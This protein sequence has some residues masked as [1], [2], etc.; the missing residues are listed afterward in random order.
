MMFVSG[1]MMAIAGFNGN[2]ND[3]K[4]LPSVIALFGFIF[5]LWS[6]YRI[7]YIKSHYDNQKNR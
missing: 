1:L 5:T 4:T 6:F 7:G 3:I 2:G